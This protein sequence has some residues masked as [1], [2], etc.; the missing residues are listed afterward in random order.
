MARSSPAA[1]RA[2]ISASPMRG[3][4]AGSL[5]V[6]AFTGRILLLRPFD[7]AARRRVPALVRGHPPDRVADV[8][9]D[10]ERPAL[11][12]RDPDR[13]SHRV[14]VAVHEA[15]QD[16]D[17]GAR[18]AASGERHEHHAVAAARAAI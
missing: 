3:S 9:S 1:T 5:A 2:A 13:P 18:G 6:W 16:L 8:I 7:D 17:R 12:D 10:E 11:V 15:L 4:S 14:A